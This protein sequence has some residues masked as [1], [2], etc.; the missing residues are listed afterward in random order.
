MPVRTVREKREESYEKGKDTKKLRKCKPRGIVA[1][2]D[3]FSCNES[4]GPTQKAC[5]GPARYENDEPPSDAMDTIEG[6]KRL[7]AIDE[8]AKLKSQTVPETLKR[9]RADIDPLE[10][11]PHT[12]S[13]N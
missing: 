6:H 5:N 10:A 8:G 1:R 13:G 4:D 11:E 7:S 2:A 9:E 3:Y 12:P